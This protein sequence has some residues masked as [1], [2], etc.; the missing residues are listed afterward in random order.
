M[1]NQ[2]SEEVKVE[3]ESLGGWI[4]IA[5]FTSDLG[6]RILAALAI[7]QE[8]A[9]SF[10]LPAI[11]GLVFLAFFIQRR[12]Q[13]A[14]Q[15][16]VSSHPVKGGRWMLALALGLLAASPLV[17]AQASRSLLRKRFFYETKREE[18]KCPPTTGLSD[19]FLVRLHVP[20]NTPIDPVVVCPVGSDGSVT[21]F[22]EGSVEHTEYFEPWPGNG[23]CRLLEIQPLAN[24]PFQIIARL[25][26]TKKSKEGV[27][28]QFARDGAEPQRIDY[29]D[30]LSWYERFVLWLF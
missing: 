23:R 14:L 8:V 26:G 7:P 4:A 20:P 24:P 1:A 30:N 6:S 28:L 27:R 2:P 29:S 15:T 25:K 11:A 19:C 5:L 3:G 10:L 13:R 16:S 22:Q 9:Q 18:N 21:G 12:R 17:M